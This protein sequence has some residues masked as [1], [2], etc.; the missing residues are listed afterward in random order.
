MGDAI[1]VARTEQSQD[2]Y[3]SFKFTPECSFFLDTGPANGAFA[4]FPCGGE[5]TNFPLPGQRLRPRLPGPSLPDATATRSPAVHHGD[6]QV[7]THNTPGPPHPA[8]PH[9]RTSSQ[10]GPIIIAPP[11][12]YG[13]AISSVARAPFRRTPDSPPATP[14]HATAASLGDLNPGKDLRGACPRHPVIRGYPHSETSVTQP[15]KTWLSVERSTPN[16]AAKSL[17]ICFL[18]IRMPKNAKSSAGGRS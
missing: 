10:P 14:V 5:R 13:S 8:L 2:R 16:T 17:Q 6:L 7:P 15:A 1:S 18:G 12:G 3:G 11:L 4:R 9:P